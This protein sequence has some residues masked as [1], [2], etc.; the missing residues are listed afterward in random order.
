MQNAARIVGVRAAST[1]DLPAIHS[2]QVKLA[3]AELPFDAN[4]DFQGITSPEKNGYIGYVNIKQKLEDSGSNHV[5]VAVTTEGVVVGVCYGMIE[6]DTIWSVHEYFGYV[7]CV[8]ICKEYRGL[9]IWPMMLEALET[10]FREKQI[11]QIRLDCYCNN[12]A[13]IRAY[14]K[15]QFRPI[16]YIMHKDL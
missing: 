16:Q 1:S 12:S 14:T 4:I 11:K 2:L 8:I 10:W 7:G 15:T 5:V 6:K 9:G 13:A 3:E